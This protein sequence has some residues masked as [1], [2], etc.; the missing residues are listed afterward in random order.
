M[1]F[2]QGESIQVQYNIFADLD[3][4]CVL[5]RQRP[6]QSDRVIGLRGI[7][8]VFQTGVSFAADFK[9]LHQRM[10]EGAVTGAVHLVR[11]VAD[12]AAGTFAVLILAGM[13]DHLDLLILN[14]YIGNVQNFVAISVCKGISV[15]QQS[16][17]RRAGI[18]D[19]ILEGAAPELGFPVERHLSLKHAV[20][21]YR[22]GTPVRKVVHV[23][24]NAVEYQYRGGSGF[25]AIYRA[26]FDGNAVVRKILQIQ[27]LDLVALQIQRSILFVR[28]IT[29]RSQGC[30]SIPHKIKGSAGGQNAPNQGLRVVDF[31]RIGDT[32]FANKEHFRTTR[33]AALLAFAL[34][35][36]FFMGAGVNGNSDSVCIYGIALIG[37][38]AVDLAAVLPVLALRCGQVGLG[39]GDFFAGAA[40]ARKFRSIYIPLIGN[41]T[42]HTVRQR[43]IYRD[44]RL[45]L[46]IRCLILDLW[47]LAYGNGVSGRGGDGDRC[48]GGRLVRRESCFAVCGQLQLI[49]ALLDIVVGGNGDGLVVSGFSRRQTGVRAHPFHVQGIHLDLAAGNGEG[50]RLTA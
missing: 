24:C 9:C 2:A 41:I 40:C 18:H 17:R 49:A 31:I 34:M 32:I 22:Q 46:L 39:Q 6:P 25:N 3:R 11:M 16:Q 30:V 14:I 43:G 33:F 19:A 35:G 44:I 28:L 15:C 1:G 42:A 48:G 47:L 21:L 4:L 13:R 20:A 26:V 5:D 27:R 29:S 50:R 23:C 8:R 7:Q 38:L 10:A 37:Q 45:H 36:V 12:S